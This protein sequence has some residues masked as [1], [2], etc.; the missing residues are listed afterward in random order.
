MNQG[1]E[2]DYE[3]LPPEPA[4]G[5]NPL[6]IVG[7]VLAFCVPPVG[8]LL[9]AIAVFMRPRGFALAGLIVSLFTNAIVGLLVLGGVYFF[10]A[11]KAIAE[12]VADSSAIIQDIETY[13]RNNNGAL[14]PDLAALGLPSEALT[15]PWGTPYRYEVLADGKS[16]SLK[17]AGPD[18]GF[19]DK[20]TAIITSDMDPRDI[21]N[22]VGDSLGEA[23]VRH[24]LQG[25]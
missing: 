14:P 20:D 18:G 5:S 23:I 1:T 25:K 21:G 4:R 19:D 3:M 13:Q 7:F 8:L 24:T 11:A 10:P 2:Y 9:S 12:V 16:W 15:D 17:V 6:G 22:T